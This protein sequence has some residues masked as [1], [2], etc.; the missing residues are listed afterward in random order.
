[1]L[2]EQPELHEMYVMISRQNDGVSRRGWGQ[3]DPN[4]LTGLECPTLLIAGEE[5]GVCAPGRI[6]SLG[7]GN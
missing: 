3:I 1:M 4:E 5:D 2:E 6:R 7:P